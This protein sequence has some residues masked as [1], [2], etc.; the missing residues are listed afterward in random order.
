[1]IGQQRA[2]RWW[3][4]AFVASSHVLLEYLPGAG[5]TTLAKIFDHGLGRME[6][7]LAA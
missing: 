7:D 3:L 6:R 2:I 4:A 1:M 5:K